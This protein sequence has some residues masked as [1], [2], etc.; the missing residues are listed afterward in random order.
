MKG[1]IAFLFDLACSVGCLLGL[2]FE[3]WG[4]IVAWIC[5]AIII[6]KVILFGL[7]G[8]SGGF[9]GIFLSAIVDIVI[10]SVVAIP[11]GIFVFHFDVVGVVFLIGC[12]HCV[13]GWI[14]TAYN[15]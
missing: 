15:L 11:L 14:A 9:F 3:G 1:L 4:H 7:T 8:S 2:F 12:F 6:L 13:V 10:P 5:L